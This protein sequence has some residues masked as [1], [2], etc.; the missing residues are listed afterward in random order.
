MPALACC[1]DAAVAP[2]GY[3][4]AGDSSLPAPV[5]FSGVFPATTNTTTASAAWSPSLSNELYRIDAWG[6]PYFT[7]NSSGNVSVRPYGSGTMPHQEIDF[8]ENSE[9]GVG[10]EIRIRARIAAPSHC[11]LSGRA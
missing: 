1:V 4:F 2:P 3:A 9:E 5:P 11:S 7:V 6:G 8:A 10:S